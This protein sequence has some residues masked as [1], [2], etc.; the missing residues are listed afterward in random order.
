MKLKLSFFAL[1]L[2]ASLPDICAQ[3]SQRSASQSAPA[4]VWQA[5]GG[6]VTLGLNR[7]LLK[8]LGVLV[9]AKSI[10]QAFE[11]SLIEMPLS[12]SSSLSFTAPSGQP[13]SIESGALQAVQAFGLSHRGNALRINALLARRRDGTVFDLEL[14]DEAGNLWFT[15]DF[16]HYGL[17][18]DERKLEIKNMNLRASAFLAQKLSLPALKDLVVGSMDFQANITGSAPIRRPETCANE[19]YNW[20]GKPLDPN[21]PALGSYQVDVLL[22]DTGRLHYKR[23]LGTCDGP[24]GLNTGRV[25][26]APDAYLAN[27]DTDTTADAPW[28]TKFSGNFAPHNNDQ[29]PFLVWNTYRINNGTG[30]IEHIGRSGVKHAFYTINVSCPA[31]DCGGGQILFRQCQDE[32]SSQNND[33]TGDLGPRSEIIPNRGLWARCD[34]V[35]DPD[36]DGDRDVL[37]ATDTSFRMLIDEAKFENPSNYTYFYESWY[38]VRDDINI[39][40]TMGSREFQPV[41]NQLWST[42]TESLYRSGPV[43]DL[44]VNP[45]NPG[46]GNYSQELVTPNGRVKLAVKTLALPGGRFRYE[47]ALMNFNLIGADTSIVGGNQSNL[48][49]SNRIAIDRF[50]ILH[51][52]QNINNIASN[53]G[54]SA[55]QNWNYA[56]QGGILFS[57]PAPAHDLEWNSMYTFVLESSEPP[58]LSE[59]QFQLRGQADVYRVQTLS[60]QR[61]EFFANGFE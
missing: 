12:E 45:Q 52:G 27:S 19:D 3:T 36:C 54:E 44:W 40:N 61:I 10:R 34:S 14:V 22:L 25:V 7:S 18:A 31:Y 51:S 5:S 30:S 53:T 58:V 32:Y 46:P 15:T 20:H 50:K 4:G 21:N 8:E 16:G 13:R 1:M 43:I 57:S 49:Q 6:T 35:Y 26:V 59:A 11:L 42:T 56:Q 29:H 55:L 28:R 60:P 24:G 47:Y 17:S 37:N 33:S 48:R 2:T 41:F 38:V 23:C 39:Y 9:S